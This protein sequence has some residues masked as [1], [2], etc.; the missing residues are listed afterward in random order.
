MSCFVHDHLLCVTSQ[1][2][3][4]LSIN[5]NREL[6]SSCLAYIRSRQTR[7]QYLLLFTSMY[8]SIEES[9]DWVRLLCWLFVL[10][11]FPQFRNRLTD[12]DE[13]RI[14]ELS[15]KDHPPRNGLGKYLLSCRFLFCLY[16]LVSWSR[17]QVAPVDRFWRSISLV[18]WRLS[19]RGYAFWGFRWYASPIRGQIPQNPN[20]G[21]VSSRFPAKLVAS[22]RTH[23]EMR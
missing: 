16:F 17:A 8:L 3:K 11:F 6:A 23:Q 10:P 7:L 9:I 13:I 15:S 14:L 2:Y 5:K 12:L 19:T 4:M 20:F 22:T 21:S 18:I 1:T